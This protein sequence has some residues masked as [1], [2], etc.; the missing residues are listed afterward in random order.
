VIERVDFY[1]EFPPDPCEAC[2]EATE[3]ARKLR[4]N[5]VVDV[6]DVREN[7]H[8]PDVKAWEDATGGYTPAIRVIR[9]GGI[10]WIRGKTEVLRFKETMEGEG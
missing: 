10:E 7:M 1:L 2:D 3:L 6:F 5:Y 9:D 8:D 4:R